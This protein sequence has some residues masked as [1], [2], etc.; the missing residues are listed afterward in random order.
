MARLDGYLFSNSLNNI[1]CAQNI[2][3][4]INYEEMYTFLL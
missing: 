3:K 1:L 4:P 2:G